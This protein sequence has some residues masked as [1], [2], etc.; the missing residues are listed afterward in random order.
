M[1]GSGQPRLP[2]I[3]GEGRWLDEPA[4][5]QTAPDAAPAN[6]TTAIVV[7]ISMPNI[8]NAFRRADRLALD[9]ELTEKV[10]QA[11]A[12]R[13]A[14]GA[15]PSPS[16]EIAASRFPG[17]GWNYRVDGGTMTIAPNRELPPPEAPLV[18]PTS[19]SSRAP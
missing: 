12:A 5:S 1:R 4:F 13:T 19:F 15:W 8:R 7:A 17:L 14:A 3:R 11:K 2:C 6:D 16:A 9:A 10:L 18:I